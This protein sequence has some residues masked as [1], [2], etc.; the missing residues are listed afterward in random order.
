[1]FEWY[2]NFLSIIVSA[3]TEISYTTTTTVAFTVT[4]STHHYLY[5]LI[6]AAE[7]NCFVFAEE[8]KA[9]LG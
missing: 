4:I 8:S 5:F 3:M 1:M 7:T 2:L 6:F 9:N